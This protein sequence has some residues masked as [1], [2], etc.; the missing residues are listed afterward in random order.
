MQKGEYLLRI[1][2]VSR[3]SGTKDETVSAAGAESAEAFFG[4]CEAPL[5]PSDSVAL[6][7]RVKGRGRLL[8]DIFN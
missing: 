5:K 7:G 8:G 2:V 6:G 4:C 1:A 3:S